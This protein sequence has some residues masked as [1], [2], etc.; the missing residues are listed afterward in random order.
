M[1]HNRIAAVLAVAVSLP[2]WSYAQTPAPATPPAVPGAAA[3]PATPAPP[4]EAQ[5]TL[6]AAIA[7]LKA[8]QTVSADIKQSVH[9][10]GQ[11]F[12]IT[13]SYLR[14]PDYRVYLQLKVNGLGNSPGTMLQVSDGTIFWEYKEVLDIPS[15]TRR[16]LPPIIELLKSPDCDPELR[17]QVLAQLGFSGPE[18]L[19]VGLREAIA[20]DQKEEGEFDGRKCWVIRGRWSDRQRLTSPEQQALPATGPLPPYVPSLAAVWID[21]ET[22]WPYQVKLTGKAL[23][24]MDLKLQTRELGPDGRPV[25]RPNLPTNVP[26]SDL[27]L[28]YSNVKLNAKLGPEF[29]AFTPPSDQIQ[30]VDETQAIASGLQAAIADRAARRKAEAAKEAPDLPIPIPVPRPAGESTPPASA[31]PAEPPAIAPPKT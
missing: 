27:T 24:L 25:G 16:E 2:L 14:A 5:Q 9:L 26:P 13:G 17:D 8:I 6:D 28:T 18:A 15:L 22:G 23:S 4:N 21:Q 31:P 10:L 7:K 11:N 20:F 1:P 3:T 30:V 29:F 19:L 12:Q